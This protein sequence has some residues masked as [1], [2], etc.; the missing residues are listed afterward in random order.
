MT[1]LMNR[2]ASYISKTLVTSTKS[3]TISLARQRSTGG[4]RRL[5]KSRIFQDHHAFMVFAGAQVVPAVC[6]HPR[7]RGRVL[8]PKIQSRRRSMTSVLDFHRLTRRRMSRPPTPSW[9]QA[10]A[11]PRLR[12]RRQYAVLDRD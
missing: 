1:F 5:M 4:E 11:R 2:P 6:S 10:I 12:A 8:T 9:E 3:F 7:R